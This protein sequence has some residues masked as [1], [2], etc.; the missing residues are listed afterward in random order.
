M[1]TCPACK[2]QIHR[3]ATRCPRCQ[4]D[5]DAAV[6]AAGEAEVRQRTRR[7]LILFAAIALGLLA[8]LLWPGNVEDIGSRVGD[9]DAANAR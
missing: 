3:D 4:T 2:S 8:W 6:M 7:K 1:K 5:F 9:Y